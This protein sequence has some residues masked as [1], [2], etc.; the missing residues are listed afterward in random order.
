MIRADKVLEHVLYCTYTCQIWLRSFVEAVLIA[1]SHDITSGTVCA[2]DTLLSPE[3]EGLTCLQVKVEQVGCAATSTLLCGCRSAAAVLAEAIRGNPRLQRLT[4]THNPIGA[5]GCRQLLQAVLVN[6]SCALDLRCS[7][8]FDGC[9]ASVEASPILS[10][11]VAAL[12][13]LDQ[14]RLGVPFEAQPHISS[15]A[16]AAALRQRVLPWHRPS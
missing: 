11:P 2:Y 6:P 15:S 4:L 7:C 12:P 13:E 3:V 5:S 16:G 14:L 9:H 8:C 1:H 10:S